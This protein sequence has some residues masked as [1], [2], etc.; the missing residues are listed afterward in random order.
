MCNNYCCYAFLEPH[1][2]PHH[3]L[4]FNI[5]FLIF[6]SFFLL[7]SQLIVIIFSNFFP[8]FYLFIFLLLSTL[9]SLFFYHFIFLIFCCSYSLPLTINLQFS[10]SFYSQFFHT[11]NVISLSF[12]THKRLFLSLIFCCS[13]S[14]SLSLSQFILF[15]VNFLIFFLH[16]NFKLMNFSII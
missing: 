10:F 13:L 1:Q 3:L 5:I 12:S 4:I 9:I 14:L 8:P 11:Q 16:L 7:I 15:L 6:K 2:R